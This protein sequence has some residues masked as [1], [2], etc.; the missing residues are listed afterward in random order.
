[1]DCVLT[2]VYVSFSFVEML[3]EKWQ[4]QL[5]LHILNYIF[6]QILKRHSSV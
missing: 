3:H 5:S 2:E 6:A 1:M 4:V